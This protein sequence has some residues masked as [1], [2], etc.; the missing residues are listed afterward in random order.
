L[1]DNEIQNLSQK[2]KDGRSSD[3]MQPKTEATY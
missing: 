1:N 3:E 2:P